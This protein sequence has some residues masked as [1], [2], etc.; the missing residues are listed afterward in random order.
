NKY[1]DLQRTVNRGLVNFIANVAAATVEGAELELTLLPID[2]L[3]LTATVGYLN[4]EYDS[5]PDLDVDGDGSPDPE[6]AKGLRLIRAPEW[7][8]SLAAVYDLSLGSAGLL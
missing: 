6:Q 2:S 8:Y 3:S 4:A 5:Y 1:E 7:S